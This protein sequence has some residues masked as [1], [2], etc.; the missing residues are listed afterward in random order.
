MQKNPRSQCFAFFLERMIWFFF[1]F[2][3][4]NSS[5]RSSLFI[6][7]AVSGLLNV[8]SLAVSWVSGL[9]PADLVTWILGRDLMASDAELI[10]HTIEVGAWLVKFSDHTYCMY[11]QCCGSRM[12]YSETGSSYEF[13]RVPDPHPDP[14][15]VI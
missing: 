3:L 13:S 2:A 1:V 9:I 15:H 10:E 14:T 6:V 8:L 4:K 5:F 12:I 11:L 7:L